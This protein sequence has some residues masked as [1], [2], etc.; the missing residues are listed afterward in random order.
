ML[1]SV[2]ARPSA[3]EIVQDSHAHKDGNTAFGAAAS[4]QSPQDKTANASEHTDKTKGKEGNS[5]SPGP[6]QLTS[7][8]QSSPVPREKCKKCEAYDFA[9]SN[10]WTLIFSAIAAIATLALAVIGVF[11]ACLAFS[12]LRILQEQTHHTQIAAEAARASAESIKRSE[13][14]WIQAGPD[15]PEFKIE[16]LA[17]PGG[18]IAVFN[19]SITNTGR[20][21]ARLLEIAARYRLIKSLNRISDVPEYNGDLEKIPLYENLL[22]P[23][24]RAWSFQPLEP[25]VLS[26]D[27]ITAI[28]KGDRTLFAYGYVNYLDVFGDRHETGFCYCYLVPQGGMVSFAKE[29]WRPYLQA[30]PAY[31]KAT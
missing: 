28:K 27:E 5:P 2:L 26:P 17:P 25:S 23:S 20:T 9:K 6:V 22:I 12:T 13:R 18:A 10:S 4:P 7:G 30:P 8:Q 31:K 24:E 19:W 15:M 16:N 1:L 21:P 3:Q 14:A 29:G 11:A